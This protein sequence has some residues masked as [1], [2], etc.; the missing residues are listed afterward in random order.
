MQ[1]RAS[2]RW[3]LCGGYAAAAASLAFGAFVLTRDDPPQKD[4]ARREPRPTVVQH[5]P[6]PTTALGVMA[7]RQW[8]QESPS[9]DHEDFDD[10]PIYDEPDHEP[11]DVLSLAERHQQFGLML[12]QTASS[13]SA[14]DEAS[15]AQRMQALVRA[16]VT[17]EYDG[18]Q[19][20]GLRVG[21]PPSSQASFMH[22]AGLKKGDLI[23]EINGQRAEDP[24]ADPSAMFRELSS[25]E[26]VDLLVIDERGST[27][28]R[29]VD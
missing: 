29:S 4:A 25:E 16:E 6:R 12:A 15:R 26:R 8:V 28:R 1:T 11:D 22:Q 17:P 10:T 18:A 24:E 7:R 20:I 19:F 27:W 5:E 13:E 2:V 21:T 3:I 9:A 23:I 14:L